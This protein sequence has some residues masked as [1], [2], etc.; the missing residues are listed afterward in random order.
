MRLYGGKPHTS[1]EGSRF[2]TLTPLRRSFHESLHVL[3]TYNSHQISAV[4]KVNAF[5]ALLTEA[6]P[7]RHLVHSHPTLH[8]SHTCASKYIAQLTLGV[9]MYFLLDGRCPASFSAGTNLLPSVYQPC[10]LVVEQMLISHPQVTSIHIPACREAAIHAR[11]S[12]KG[13]APSL[14][15]LQ[16]TSSKQGPLASAPAGV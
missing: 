14:V 15:R 5:S 11:P 16:P 3:L 7:C 8:A 6:L 9:C 13:K 12:A 2:A 4:H 10:I 1:A